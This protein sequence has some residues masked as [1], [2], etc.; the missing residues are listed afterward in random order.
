MGYTVPTTEKAKEKFYKIISAADKLFS[1]NGYEKTSINNIT[2]LAN[3]ATG[4]FYLYF[5]DKIS[6]YHYLLFD[7]QER[8]KY[9]IR[10][11]ISGTNDRKEKERLGIIA[12]LEFINENPNTYDIVWQSISIDK[13]LFINYYKKFSYSYEQGLKKD[14]NQLTDVNLDYCSLALMG[15]SSFLGL[16]QKL[17]NQPLTCEQINDVAN[18]IINILE[19]GLFKK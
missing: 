18:T 6:I 5:D 17:N 9:Y 10:K 7:Y 8:I 4:T 15:I 2:S 19:N 14:S 1:E 13:T 3:V 11:K 12:W 16:K